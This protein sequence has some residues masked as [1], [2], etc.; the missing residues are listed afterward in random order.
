[1]ACDVMCTSAPVIIIRPRLN[2]TDL[3]LMTCRPEYGEDAAAVFNLLTGF[4]EFEGNIQTDGGPVRI[5]IAHVGTHQTRNRLP[6]PATRTDYRQDELLV[7]KPVIEA[8]YEASQAGVKI[9]LVVRGILRPGV[10]EFSPDH[11]AVSWTGS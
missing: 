7:D 10:Q 5:P 4:R 11:R 8:L 2:Y 1:M 6:A 9:D 3:G